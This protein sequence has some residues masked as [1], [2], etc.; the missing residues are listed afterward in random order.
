[1]LGKEV[2]PIHEM[3][4]EGNI[5]Y[6]FMNISCDSKT[7]L[8]TDRTSVEFTAMVFE[9]EEDEV[10]RRNGPIQMLLIYIYGGFVNSQDTEARKYRIYSSIFKKILLSLITFRSTFLHVIRNTFKVYEQNV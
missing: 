8:E 2:M 3:E 10:V 9:I 6:I 1:M 7:V 5:Q 4:I